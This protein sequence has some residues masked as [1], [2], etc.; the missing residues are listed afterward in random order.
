MM[1]NGSDKQVFS[2]VKLVVQFTFVSE[3]ESL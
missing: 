1:N 2:R 3:M